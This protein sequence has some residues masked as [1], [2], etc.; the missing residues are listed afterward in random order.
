MLH[1]R[2]I[3]ALREED[4]NACVKIQA[5]GSQPPFLNVPIRNQRMCMKDAEN[6]FTH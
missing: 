2:Y 6:S 1:D 5:R 4:E 3:K